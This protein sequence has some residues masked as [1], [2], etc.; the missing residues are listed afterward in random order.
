M[1]MSQTSCDLV[2]APEEEVAGKPR[3]SRGPRCSVSSSR[4]PLLHPVHATATGIATP[5]TWMDRGTIYSQPK[6]RGIATPGSMDSTGT[7]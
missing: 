5:G 7:A 4:G 1:Y 6:I 2:K 3:H